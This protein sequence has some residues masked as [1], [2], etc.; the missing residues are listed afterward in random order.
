M[1]KRHGYTRIVY[2]TEPLQ[3]IVK[4]KKYMGE[5]ESLVEATGS[6]QGVSK[7]KKWRAASR[8]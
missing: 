6:A 5:E 3:A 4:G 8:S 2:T 7:G 1:R